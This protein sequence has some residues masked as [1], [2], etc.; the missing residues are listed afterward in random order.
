MN[1]QKIIK[2]IVLL[3]I[4]AMAATAKAPLGPTLG[5]YGIP[6]AEFCNKF[7][8]MTNIYREGTIITTKLTVY[9]TREYEIEL[10]DPFSTFY[11]KKAIGI[12]KGIGYIYNIRKG[13]YKKQEKMN[14]ITPTPILYEICK[15]K[16]EKNNALKNIPIESLYRSILGTAK[17]MGLIIMPT[18]TL[19]EIHNVK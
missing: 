12:Q 7:N 9:D 8:T 3:K 5:Q 14:Y 19:K 1:E 2:N 11:I 18:Q 4:P 10:L 15:I 13:N 6:I 16:K 17:S